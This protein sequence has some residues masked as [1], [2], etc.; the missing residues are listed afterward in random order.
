MEKTIAT[1]L[2]ERPLSMRN[3]LGLVLQRFSRISIIALVVVICAGNITNSFFL[4]WGFRDDQRPEIYNA[5]NYLESYSL[6]GMMYGSA[7]KPFVYRAAVPRVIKWAV[8]RLDPA[9]QEKV[10][11]GIKE[12]DSLRKSYASGLPAKYWTAEVAIT[13]HALYM[14]I[15]GVNILLLFTVYRIAR[16]HGFA[17]GQS[18]LFVAATS[19]VYPLTF[20]QGGYFYDFIEQLGA[21]VACY[22]VL[23]KR[24]LLATLTIFAFAFNKETFFLVPVALFALTAGQLS[25]RQ[26]LAW[27]GA[28]L[29]GCAVARYVITSPYAVNP[30]GAVEIHLM[31]NLKFWLNPASFLTFYNLVGRGIYTPSVQNPIVLVP[32]LIFFR[33]AWRNSPP[34]YRYFF[35]AAFWPLLLLFAV[36]GFKDEVRNFSLAFPALVLLATQG[37]RNFDSLFSWARKG[38]DRGTGGNIG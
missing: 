23:R 32:A 27:A 18:L 11:S 38:G 34:N 4:K 20:Q 37:A 24:M 26:R 35:H 30:G 36:F 28:Q 1:T 29:V 3:Q 16:F 14:L 8:D 33:C 22:L 9:F 25:L 10:F 6:A 19:L 13:Y 31:E 21:L 7:P 17:F 15:V 5:D 12:Y 2:P